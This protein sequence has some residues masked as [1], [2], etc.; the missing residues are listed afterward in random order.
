MIAGAITRMSY[1]EVCYWYAH[2]RSEHGG[3]ALR[4]LRVLLAPE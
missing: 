3:R 4:A 2:V 1:E